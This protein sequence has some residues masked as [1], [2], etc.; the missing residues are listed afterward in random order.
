MKKRKKADPVVSEIERALD[1]GQF[2]S[3]NRSWEFVRELEATKKRIDT[4]VKNGEAE[5]AVGLYEMFFSGCYEKAEEI[6]DSSGNLGMFFGE[7]FC[8]WIKA[9]QKAGCKADETVQFFCYD[10]EQDI[11]QVLNKAGFQ[12][13]R[14]HFQDQF[15]NAFVPYTSKAPKFI[16]D[17]PADVYRN[18][19]IL[20]KICIVKKD[21]QSYLTLCE[22][23]VASP[24]DCENIAMLYKK[25][26]HFADALAWVEKGLTLEKKRKWGNQSSYG[27]TSMRQ[28]LLDKLGRSEDAFESAWSEFKKYPSVYGYDELMKYIPKQ[29]FK[30][31][32]EKTLLEAK[33][34]SLSA[35]IEIC[36]KTKEWDILS[37]RIVSVEHDKLEQI[38]H[39]ITE[40]AAKGLAKKHCRAAAKIYGAM[41]MRI[42]KKRKSKYYW[43]ALEHFRKTGKLYKKAGHEQVWVSLV[44]RVRKDHSRKY[45]FIGD[46]EKI[47]EGRVPESPETFEKRVRKRWVKQ[48]SD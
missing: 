32:H 2:I 24:K 19:D 20:K 30:K 15:E 14:K 47:V 11:A 43:H 36:N 22:K 39:Y 41:G 18:V 34:T 21:I 29:D 5:R 40:K 42:L 38:S 25:K 16:Y 17:Y 28:E 4:L 10:I 44:D 26:K 3:Y 9:R 45:S 27:L 7:L 35:F 31:W 23:T 13:F 1:L 37:E 48:T 12:L 33:K 6:D 46:F 8:A